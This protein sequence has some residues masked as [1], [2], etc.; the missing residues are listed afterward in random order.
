MSQIFPGIIV[1][2]REG[3]EAFLI[4]SLMLE[5]LKKLDKRNMMKSVTRG[6]VTGLGVSVLFGIVL[7][8]IV[9]SL[10]NS[11]GAVGKLWEA[12]A[13]LAAVV[14][15]SYFI[16][17]MMKHGSGMV[18]EIHSNV[19]RNL[20]GKGLFI[21]ATI[22]V[23]RE[24][25][26]IA[27]FAF[28]A[29]NK[30]I[31]L[32]GT[33]TGVIIAAGLAYLIYRS[34]VKVDI[35]LIFCITLIYLILQAAYLFG[36]AVHELLSALKETGALQPDSTLYTKVYNFKDTILDHKKGVLG[37]FLNVTVGWYSRP[38][39]I[40]FVLQGVYLVTFGIIWKLMGRSKEKIE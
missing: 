6:M 33:L 13:S 9:S 4:I 16:Y 31:Y 20:S 3:L 12:G 11:S 2:F 24:G 29:E 27:L 22:A 23:A 35:G 26:E 25:A 40:Q 19:D 17:W 34:L 7:W 5:Y 8:L 15:I 36:Y 30:A 21:L 28:S 10:E 37:I 32:A 38:E 14:F 1:G 18:K 39:I